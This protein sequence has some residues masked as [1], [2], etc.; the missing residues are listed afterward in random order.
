MNGTERKDRS[1]RRQADG[2][3]CVTIEIDLGRVADM[4]REEGFITPL[5]EDDK[6]TVAKGIE[7]LLDLID[8][9][10]GDV[11]SAA[12]SKADDNAYRPRRVGLRPC[13]AR[14]R[15]QRGSAA[16][17]AARHKNV[18][19]GSFIAVPPRR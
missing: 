4:L 12:G 19:R 14:H 10:R 7:Q 5:G 16:A 18:R 2:L 9:A 13:D 8:A 17:P 11:V 3:G 15:R 1:R 6:A